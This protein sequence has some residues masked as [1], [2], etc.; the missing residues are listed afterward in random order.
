MADHALPADADRN[1]LGPGNIGSWRAHMNALQSVV[2]NNLSS[3]LIMEDDLDWDIRIKSQ[4][5][6][7]AKGTRALTQPLVG[8]GYADP[9]LATRASARDV[10]P[11]DHDIYPDTAPSTT[12]AILS[13]YGDNWDVLWVGHC[14][15]RFP[16]PDQT[17]PKGRYAIFNDDTVPTFHHR[18][19][20]HEEVHIQY[21]DQTR[22]IHHAMGPICTFAYAVSQRGAR[23][24]LQEIGIESF[25]G[26]YDNLM[27]GFCDRH[28]CI[29]SQPQYFNHW[30]AA[31]SG[32][33]DSE[34]NGFG[35]GQF[36][37]KGF[38]ENIRKSTRLNVH[39]FLDGASEFDD[40]FPD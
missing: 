31:G 38:S 37:E 7:F 4:M 9:T 20:L 35:N 40:Q 17:I 3:A 36:R 15:V 18:K 33:R 39:R 14:G 28:T 34:I 23:R 10:T 5:V 6:D 26:P 8:G 25:R 2:A 30:R 32:D 12:Q 1:N 24:I 29:T 19:T 27:A 11:L 13:P 21:R 22:I 16:A